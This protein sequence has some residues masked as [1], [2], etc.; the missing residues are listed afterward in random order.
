M[1]GAL[2]V[3]A[4]VIYRSQLQHDL[5]GL[6]LASVFPSHLV[7]YYVLMPQWLFSSAISTC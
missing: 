5:L 3:Q 7:K 6:E 1:D 4:I 2:Q